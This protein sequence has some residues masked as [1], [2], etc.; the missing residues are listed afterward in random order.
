MLATNTSSVSVAKAM[1]LSL[2]KTGI[3][4]MAK[5]KFT[6]PKI[7]LMAEFEIFREAV[8]HPQACD[9]QVEEMQRSFMAGAS[10]A[11]AIIMETT[12]QKHENGEL[13]QEAVSNVF[14]VLKSEIEAF[15]QS[16]ADMDQKLDS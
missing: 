13:D 12:Q 9:Q 10:I 2:I 3:F 15:A 1:Y 16:Q 11:F 5:N 4:I 8:I 7:S 6:Q 14:H